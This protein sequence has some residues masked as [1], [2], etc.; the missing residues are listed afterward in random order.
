MS[1]SPEKTESTWHLD[2]RFPIAL[3][4][5]IALQ[6]VGLVSYVVSTNV[7]VDYRLQ[8]LEKTDQQVARVPMDIALVKQ[9]IR[10]IKD[11]VSDNTEQL[12]RIEDK[13]DRLQDAN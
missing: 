1:D 8:A 5:T 11:D 7:S 12:D 4:V 9:E 3:I 13:I 10:S 2:K 6:T